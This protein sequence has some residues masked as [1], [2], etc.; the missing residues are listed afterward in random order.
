MGVVKLFAPFGG[1]ALIRLVTS[2]D[3]RFGE[4]RFDNAHERQPIPAIL[5]G[6]R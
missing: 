2:T 5:L 6:R 1:Q 4:E 3:R